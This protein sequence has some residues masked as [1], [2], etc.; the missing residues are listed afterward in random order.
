M[1]IRHGVVSRLLAPELRGAVADPFLMLLLASYTFM[2][3]VPSE[4]L[5]VAV[6]SP[7]DPEAKTPVV[8]VHAEKVEW[9]LPKRKNRGRPTSIWRGCWCS[10]CVHTCPVHTLGVFFSA[11]A[12][13]GLAAFPAI[14]S[15]PCWAEVAGLP[16]C[17]RCTAVGAVPPTRLEARPRPRHGG[18]WQDYARDLSG[19]RLVQTWLAWELPR[20]GGS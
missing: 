19:G 8:R 14:P 11:K 15:R 12:A 6:E 20:H 10:T 5:P 7:N 13:C 3:R 16:T 2:L 18:R 9:H 4:G 1:F 17:S